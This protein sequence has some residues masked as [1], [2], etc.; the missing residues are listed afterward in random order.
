ML[1]AVEGATCKLEQLVRLRRSVRVGI[2]RCPDAGDYGQGEDDS[3]CQVQR[4]GELCVDGEPHQCRACCHRDEPHEHG[5]QE[6]SSP[7]SR[8]HAHLPAFALGLNPRLFRFGDRIILPRPPQGRSS[9]RPSEPSL[10]SFS[11]IGT[12]ISASVGLRC[13]LLSSCRGTTLFQLA[14]P[15]APIGTRPSGCPPEL[16]P[17]FP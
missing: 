12:P 7:N 4:D 9:G 11:S 13:P 6:T 10:R 1:R 2:E 8:I 16:E 17:R 3:R 14:F 5:D 15:F